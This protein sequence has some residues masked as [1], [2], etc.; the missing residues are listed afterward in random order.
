MHLVEA[1]VLFGTMGMMILIGAVLTIVAIGFVLLWIA[2]VLLAVAFFSIPAQPA[3]PTATS[4]AQ[5]QQ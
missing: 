3:Q 2:L 1:R 5:A 4:P